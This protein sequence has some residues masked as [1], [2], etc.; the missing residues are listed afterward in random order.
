M[1][2]TLINREGSQ[3]IGTGL[4]QNMLHL[5]RLARAE[6]MVCKG[7]HA[8]VTQKWVEWGCSPAISRETCAQRHIWTSVLQ[9]EGRRCDLYLSIMTKATPRF[10]MLLAPTCYPYRFRQHLVY[11]GVSDSTNASIHI[12]IKI[13]QILLIQGRWEPWAQTEGSS[14]LRAWHRAVAQNMAAKWMMDK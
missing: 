14:Q 13:S 4:Q 8:K 2:I 10:S 3:N 7:S 12:W 5:L 11:L 1:H 9:A 6:V